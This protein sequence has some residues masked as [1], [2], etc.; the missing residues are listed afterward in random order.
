MDALGDDSA[1]EGPL[2]EY[3]AMRAEIL[4]C[5]QHMALL[6]NLLIATNALSSA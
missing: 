5:S 2:A 3:V 6:F 1:N 4:H